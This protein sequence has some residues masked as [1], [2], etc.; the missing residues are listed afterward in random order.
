VCILVIGFLTFVCEYL[1]HEC[2]IHNC[3]HCI[4]CRFQNADHNTLRF[5][6]SSFHLEKSR[7]R[8]VVIVVLSLLRMVFMIIAFFFPAA[9]QTTIRQVQLYSCG[10][11]R[12]HD[13]G[14]FLISSSG[15]QRRALV[16]WT[17]IQLYTNH[18]R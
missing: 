15:V 12:V 13:S 16:Q 6:P 8:S 1:S 3:C 2:G 11:W 4:V 18:Q 9:S 17:H 10:T 5:A 14:N 7:F